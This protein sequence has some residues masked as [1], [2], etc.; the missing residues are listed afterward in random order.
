M[1][2]ANK[3]QRSKGL[4]SLQASKPVF[5]PPRR[6]GPPLTADHGLAGVEAVGPHVPLR[7]GP[8]VVVAHVRA[9][10]H[11]RRGRLQGTHALARQSEVCR[12]CSKFVGSKPCVTGGCSLYK[13]VSTIE[14]QR[15]LLR[16]RTVGAEEHGVVATAPA[17]HQQRQEAWR[18]GCT[19]A[20]RHAVAWLP[21]TTALLDVFSNTSGSIVSERLHRG[22]GV[23]EVGVPAESILRL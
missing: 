20:A 8:R 2:D 11:H 10:S 22:S 15:I 19:T 9:G 3:L 5:H 12:F 4:S 7:R 17:A 21:D 14:P 18:C 13:E 1:L 16:R 6:P 23:L